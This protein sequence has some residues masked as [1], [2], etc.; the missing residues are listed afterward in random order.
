MF[1]ITQKLPP[2]FCYFAIFSAG[3]FLSS[4]QMGEYLSEYSVVVG[5]VASVVDGKGNH[6]KVACMAF[7]G[8]MI[9]LGHK[10]SVIEESTASKGAENDMAHTSLDQGRKLRLNARLHLLVWVEI[11]RKV[12]SSSTIDGSRA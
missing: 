8:A 1:C 12:V 9:L 5:A 4:E 7:D 2:P 3:R 6:V 11:S 10:I